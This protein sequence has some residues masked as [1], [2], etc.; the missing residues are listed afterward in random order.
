MIPGGIAAATTVVAE[1]GDV[2]QV[3]PTSSGRARPDDRAVLA[4]WERGSLATSANRPVALLSALLPGCPP[5]EEL[6]RL[7]LGR[8]D[9]LLL[10]L[11]G[12][13]FTAAIDG[14]MD[15]AACA[16]QMEVTIA[17]AELL[18]AGEMAEPEP[19]ARDGWRIDWRLPDSR[20]LAAAAVAA[21]D[22]EAERILLERC[23]ISVTGPS[24]HG[25]R[26]GRDG[27]ADVPDGVRAELAAA[28]DRCDPLADIQLQV[29]CPACGRRQAVGLPVADFAWSEVA[30]QAAEV[31]RDV[32][33]L[34]SAYGWTEDEVLV[35]TP[36]R[37]RAY[38]ALA[39]G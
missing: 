35:L 39:H 21:D 10:E 28:M 11:L 37:R 17:C 4:A 8:R 33:E 16:E 1:G 22:A 31:L 2:L 7:S 27:A 6:A 25:R 30:R 18:A 32:A 3:S 5:E 13:N 24:G 9:R 19:L 36:A 29:T 14:V 20:D 26:P 38:L 23:V 15:C 12:D 34:A